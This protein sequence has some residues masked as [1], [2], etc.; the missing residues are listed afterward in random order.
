MKSVGVLKDQLAKQGQGSLMKT[1]PS[2][3]TNVECCG[4]KGDGSILK[5]SPENKL[6]A[7]AYHMLKY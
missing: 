2:I 7:D 1:G 5:D 6:G 3:Y 4:R